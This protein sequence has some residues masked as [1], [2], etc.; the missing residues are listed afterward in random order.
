[1]EHGKHQ[2]EAPVADLQPLD[3]KQLLQ[4]VAEDPSLDEF[5]ERCPPLARADAEAMLRKFRA[6]RASWGAGKGKAE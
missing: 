3:A 5:F 6:E 2:P 4:Q 1:M